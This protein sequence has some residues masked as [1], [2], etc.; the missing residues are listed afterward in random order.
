MGWTINDIETFLAVLDAG[1]I[2]GA[3]ARADLSKSVVSKRISDFEAALG[4][5]LF[6]RH[7]GRIAPTDTAHALAERLRPALAELVA[8]TE[9]VA[10]GE[11][12]LRGRLSVAAPM[13]FGIRHLGPVIAGFARAHPGLEIVLDYDDQLTDLGRS[14]FDVGLRIGLM[15]DSTLM[16]R[17]V[18]EDPRALV[19][20]PDY[21]A[22]HGP[23]ATPAQLPD[24]EIILYLNARL[25]EIWPFGPEI[26][27]PRPGRVTANNG[28]AMRDLAIGGVGLAL[29]PL[30]IVHDAL[31]D[32][33][34]VR[35][36]PGLPQQPLPVSLV[37]PPV[38]PM[39]R[40]LRLFIDHVTNAF[41]DSP[42][43]QRGLQDGDDEGETG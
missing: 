39:P 25:S 41:A 42:P 11:A 7:A 37:W 43:W 28:E 29:L 30:F 40:K 31:R 1:S 38:R 2:S 32:G 9:S 23:V 27:P 33:R 4:V 26:R 22:R 15:K 19:A 13:S 34:L 17:R 3:A 36:L 20:S 6:T 21:L 14:G 8:A 10:G 12:E 16:A 35:L 18:C 24:H 5:P